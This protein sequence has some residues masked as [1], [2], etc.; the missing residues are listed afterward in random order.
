[1]LRS[2]PRAEVGAMWMGARLST[3]DR[4]FLFILHPFGFN[5]V[6]LGGMGTGPPSITDRNWRLCLFLFPASVFCFF[7]P[8]TVDIHLQNNRMMNQP[9]YCRSSGHRVFKYFFPLGKKKI[10]GDHYTAA[11]IAMGK[12]RKKDL[13]LLTALLY[14]TDIVNKNGVIPGEFLQDF[15]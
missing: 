15:W 4:V 7:K 11:F 8:V 9:V 12:Q 2:D 13:H 6:N 10:T 5:A 3:A 14:I 1:M